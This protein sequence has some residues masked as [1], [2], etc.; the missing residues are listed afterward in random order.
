MVDQ[1]P[2]RSLEAPQRVAVVHLSPSVTQLRGVL[3]KE[4]SRLSMQDLAV[5]LIYILS[6]LVPGMYKVV[7]Y[8][9]CVLFTIRRIAVR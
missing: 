3:T 5:H 7:Q 2:V 8:F 9:M 4:F 1:E 6:L